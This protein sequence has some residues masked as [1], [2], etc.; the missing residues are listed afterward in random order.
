LK[1]TRAAKID[2]LRARRRIKAGSLPAR[3]NDIAAPPPTEA[4]AGRF[5]RRRHGLIAYRRR[6]VSLASQSVCAA[7][8]PGRLLFSR[9]F[10]AA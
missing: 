5:V 10:C 9:R 3:P 1:R 8:N 6:A 4:F 2:L 7:I